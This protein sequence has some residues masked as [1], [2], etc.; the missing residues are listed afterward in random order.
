MS[1]RYVNTLLTAIIMIL[2]S[3]NGVLDFSEK[4]NET[5]ELLELVDPL[6]APTDPGHTVFAQYITSDNCG[7]CYQYGSPG[8]KQ[9]KNSL[10]DRYVYISYHLSLIHI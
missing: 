10:P 1:A 7:F 9:V 6:L 3:M 2:V 4:E 5:P 8:H